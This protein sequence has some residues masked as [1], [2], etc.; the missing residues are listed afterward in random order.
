VARID[1]TPD[2]IFPLLVDRLIDQVD[3]LGASNCFLSLEPDTVPGTISGDFCV[4]VSPAPHWRFD[5]SLFDGGEEE[6]AHVVWQV[7]FTIHCLANV[8]EAGRDAEFFTNKTLGVMRTATNVLKAILGFDPVDGDGN[9]VLAQ[10]IQPSDGSIDRETRNQ[11][12]LQF[13]T[14]INFNWD[15]TS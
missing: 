2:V 5:E 8:D 10:P 9:K 15:L 3:G 4:I 12:F 14:S 6:L 1:S 13:G 11:G 7:V